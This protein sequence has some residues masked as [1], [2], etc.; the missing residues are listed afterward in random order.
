MVY[1]DIDLIN[2]PC[3]ILD[4]RFVSRKGR[5]HSIIRHHI[6]PTGPVLMDE[7]RDIRHVLSALDNKQGCK[8]QGTFYKH[9]VMNSFYITLGNPP[10]LSRVI[11]ER[12]G[13]M[14]DLS[15]KI[16]DFMLG[17]FNSRH[18]YERYDS[19]IAVSTK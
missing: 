13:Y 11:M 14:F 18:Y 16:N 1:I 17:D 4:L 10:V 19:I 9:F 6:T 2:V 15:H 12:P 7:D 3:E 8:I 5:E